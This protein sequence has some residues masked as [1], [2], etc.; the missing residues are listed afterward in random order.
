MLG[1]RTGAPPWAFPRLGSGWMVVAGLLFACMGVFVKLG[2]QHFSGAEMV[3]WRSLFGALTVFTVVR[4][5][6]QPAYSPHWRVH[7][8]RSLAGL[9]GML[10][11]FHVIGVLPLSTAT[12]LNYTSPVFLVVLSAIVLKE[13]LRP[14]LVAAVVVGFVGVVLLLRPTFAAN[15]TVAAVLGLASGLCAGI[16]FLTTKQLGQAGEPAWRIVLYFTTVSTLGAGIFALFEGFHAF[17]LDGLLILVGLAMCATLGQLAMTRAYRDGDTLTVG[18]L[19]YTTVVFT[20]LLSI[21][22]WAEGVPAASWLAMGL[23]MFSGILAARLTS[24][25]ATPQP[26]P[27]QMEGITK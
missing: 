3:F 19:A 23:I 9:A 14:S 11:L 26:A 22:I 6:G 21:L 27:D 15:Q 24:G 7:V 8:F 25:T 1:A 10:L 16:A 17:G 4:A 20:A 13:R 5:R 12:T 2:T 18:S